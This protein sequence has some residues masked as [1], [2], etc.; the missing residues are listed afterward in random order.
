MFFLN[1][2]RNE[3]SENNIHVFCA[4]KRKAKIILEREFRPI[5]SPT[6]A[7]P[8]FESKG[9]AQDPAQERGP[10]SVIVELAYSHIR[11]P[12]SHW[13]CYISGESDGNEFKFRGKT[14]NFQ[15]S[16]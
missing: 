8:A 4:S 1:L 11:A 14:K 9:L 16:F 7:A 13:V 12:V 10:Y 6:A 2:R 15:A 3:Q 5:F